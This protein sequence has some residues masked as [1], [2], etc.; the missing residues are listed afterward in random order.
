M[1][2]QCVCIHIYIHT[3]IYIRGV[4]ACMC[5]EL[6]WGD[7]KIIDKSQAYSTKTQHI[8]Q[9]LNYLVLNKAPKY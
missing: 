8:Q 7:I 1:C 6:G 2:V 3:Y 4:R 5:D 9:S